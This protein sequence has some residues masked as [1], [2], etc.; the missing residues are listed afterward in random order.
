MLHACVQA[1]FQKIF[2]FFRK[3]TIKTVTPMINPV[4]IVET[5]LI[6]FMPNIL[7]NM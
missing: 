4:M 7:K 6:N 3:Y 2:L 5:D 1:K